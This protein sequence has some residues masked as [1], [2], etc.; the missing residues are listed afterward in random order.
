MPKTKEILSIEDIRLMVD[1]FY[2]KVRK[3]VLLADI[4]N[5]KIGNRWPEHLEKLYR[6][7]QTILLNEHTYQGNP[8]MP[9][10]QLSLEKE[11]FNRWLLL[12]YQTIDENF[13]GEKAKEAKSRAEN[14][15]EMFYHKN[16]YF[17]EN[18]EKLINS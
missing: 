11:H 14:M 1:T 9:H 7:W 13:D 10:A 5:S 6:F 16:K 17:R 4:F 15:A 8:F 2:S 12:F 18:P 3:D